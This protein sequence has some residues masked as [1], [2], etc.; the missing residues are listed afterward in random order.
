MSDRIDDFFGHFTIA[1][2]SIDCKRGFFEYLRITGVVTAIGQILGT[3]CLGYTFTVA[4]SIYRVFDCNSVTGR[5]IFVPRYCLTG[6]GLPV[7][8]KRLRGDL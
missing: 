4:I 1:A 2:I 3:C 5:I 7:R 8:F 6:N